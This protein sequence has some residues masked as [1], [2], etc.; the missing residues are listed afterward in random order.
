MTDIHAN[1]H[2]VKTCG[3][4][5]TVLV[6]T[7]VPTLRKRRRH[8]VSFLTKNLFAI[9]NWWKRKISFLQWSVADVS[10]TLQ[11]KPEILGQQQPQKWLRFVFMCHAF[12]F[13]LLFSVLLILVWL[14]LCLRDIFE[15]HKEH[16]VDWVRKLWYWGREK[17]RTNCIQ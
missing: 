10:S 2:L 3:K 12:S 11:A 9:D 7:K 16:E 1:L 5:Y 15:R 6:H 17:S 8:K 13:V 14:E 4:S